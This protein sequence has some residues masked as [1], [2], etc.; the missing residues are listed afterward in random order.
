MGEEQGH[1]DEA[2]SGGYVGMSGLEFRMHECG[3]HHKP[4][5]KDMEI[6]EI[7]WESTWNEKRRG[8]P[9]WKLDIE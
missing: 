1:G 9:P 6:D 4:G 8:G 5:I 3:S 7:T 2:P